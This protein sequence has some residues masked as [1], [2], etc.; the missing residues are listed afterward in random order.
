MI[1]NL[2][3]VLQ[4]YVQKLKLPDVYFKPLPYQARALERQRTSNPS[5]ASKLVG[6]P[7]SI[8]HSVR[9][10]CCPKEGTKTPKHQ[11]HCRTTGIVA[12]TTTAPRSDN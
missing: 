8:D 7:A 2:D 10:A 12:V 1:K 4:P 3:E 9:K 6:E 5:L 11:R